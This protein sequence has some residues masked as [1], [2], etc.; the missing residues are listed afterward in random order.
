[1]HVAPSRRKAATA[2]IF[3]TA[4]LD[5][6]AMGIVSPV[7]PTIIKDFTGS[8]ADAGLWNGVLLAAW[9]VMQFVGS[10]IMGS[11][12]DAYGRRPVILISTAG[13]AANWLLMALA[14]NL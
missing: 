7:L 13:L 6:F 3:I 5:V 1:M 11:L 12:S 8:S 4:C 2:F 14:P 9:G 10:P